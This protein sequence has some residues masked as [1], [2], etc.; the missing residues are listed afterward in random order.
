[1][2]TPRVNWALFILFFLAA[3]GVL[4]AALISPPFRAIAYAPLREL[5]LPP[6]APIQVSLLYSTEK[7][8]WLKEVITNFEES[9]PTVDGHPVQV[10]LKAMGSREIY[11]S[12][13][14][15]SEKPDLISPA[16]SL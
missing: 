8:A 1:M 5:I 12:V 9:H 14:D 10:T 6:P 2:Y 15:G 11:L 13:L 3:I 16:S 7:D 4:T